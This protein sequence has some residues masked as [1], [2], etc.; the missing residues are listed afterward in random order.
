MAM[1]IEDLCLF[2]MAEKWYS[3]PR[4]GAIETAGTGH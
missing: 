3:I 1:K 2:P 4:A